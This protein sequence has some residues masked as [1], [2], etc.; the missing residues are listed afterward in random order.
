MSFFEELK[1]RNVFRVAVA[2]LV[3]AWV[4][5][6]VADIVL[7][8]IA[9][10]AWVIQAAMLFLALGLPVALIVAWAYELTPEGI[11]KEKDVDRTQS[12]TH[13]TG[14]KLDFTIIGILAVA[15]VVLLLDRF[16]GS[17][18]EPQSD[19]VSD[20]SAQVES[21][22]EHETVEEEPDPFKFS[23]Q[24]VAVLP[25]VNM[26]SDP[27]QEF[28]SDGISEEIL[29]ALARV[30]ELKVAG[31]TSSFAF[32]G[33][34]QNLLEIGNALGVEHIL[35]G[36]VRKAG[37]TVRITAQLIKV[38][39]G[40]HLW[41]DTYDRELDDIFAIQDEIA[42]A[43][44]EQ[45]KLALI[46]FEPEAT[47]AASTR[48]DS[49]AYDLYLLARQRIY[50]RKRLSIESAVELLDR[51]MAID[52]KYAPVYAQR[53]IAALLL[54]TETYGGKPPAEALVE[55]RF[56]LE[57]ALQLDPDLAEGWAGMGLLHS[58]V[59]GEN[60]QGIAALEKA[61]A[62]NPNLIDASNWLQVIYV[63]TGDRRR[64]LA[65]AE[66]IVE[67]DPLYP[68]GFS[69]T[70]DGYNEFGLQEKSWAL[71]ERIRPFL[72]GDPQVLQAE[73]NTWI[74]LGQPA[75]AIPL[76]EAAL[77]S[78]PSDGV[79]K[80]LLSVCLLGTGQFEQLLTVDVPWARHLSLWQ[81]GRPEE[82]RMLAAEIASDGNI[83]PLVFD[84]YNRGLHRELVAFIE[85]RWPD[86]AALEAQY[87]NDGD[88]YDLMMDIANA[89]SGVGNE[90]KFSDAMNRV[91]RSHD[92]NIE[93]GI[94]SGWLALGEARYYVLLG[95][96][97]RAMEWLAKAADRE[98]VLVSEK[99]AVI[100]PEFGIFSGDPEYDS[101]QSRLFERV[102]T[103][104]AELGLEP[105]SI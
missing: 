36:S 20:S 22:V 102:N 60:E 41:S 26:S 25:F 88:D 73:A 70:V 80:N 90:E 99:L 24:S 103:Q 69:N 23:D 84:Y 29:N 16:S 68:P 55:G 9:A 48:T 63:Q 17:V 42:G 93:Q 15:V 92:H 79:M 1:R 19:R 21:A 50:E 12:I 6:Q 82:S 83:A 64:A 104:R 27:E 87:P 59:P 4:V 96:R 76:L 5:L 71:I 105:M 46:G 18:D 77:E 37:N 86:L 57:K 65:I 38:D 33:Q 13:K 44:L 66:D 91:R 28:F 35:E 56:Y 72:P 51:A 11:K 30:K 54:S 39:D 81:L 45:L 94:D 3:T 100:W 62:I 89:Y 31:R 32:K 7:E 2:Y 10:P 34:N 58:R 95:D 75:K 85:S 67:R 74:S 78:Q 97:V 101:M 53:G 47:M 61:L 52:P 8:N 49:E 98:D 40:Y 43:I 14:R